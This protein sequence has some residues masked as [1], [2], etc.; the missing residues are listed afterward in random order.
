[1][2]TC[3]KPT[4][5]LIAQCCGEKPLYS[6]HKTRRIVIATNDIEGYTLIRAALAHLWLFK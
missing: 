2:T 1:L 3:A 4:R 6:P 5:I